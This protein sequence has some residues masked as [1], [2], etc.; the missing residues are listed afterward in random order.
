MDVVGKKWSLLVVAILGNE[1]VKRFN[2]LREEL[3]GISPKTLSDTLKKLEKLGLV[4]KEVLP[5][6]PP[7]VKYSLTRDGRELRER[8]VPLL[9]WVSARGAKQQPWCP[10]RMSGTG[11]R[12]IR[13]ES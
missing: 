4:G 5:T 11:A 8:L 12:K 1:G 6:S 7:S 3:K 2:E 13:G 10:V 9:E